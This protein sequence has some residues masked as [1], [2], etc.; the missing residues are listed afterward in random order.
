MVREFKLLNEKGQKYSLMDIEN[1]CLLTGPSGLGYSYN[2]EYEQIGHTFISSLR[3]IQQGAIN[4]TLNF[5][6]YEN[7]KSFVDFVE[8]SETLRFVYEVP[9][10]GTLKQYLKDIQIQ[11]LG[12][13]EMQ[14][15]G[16]ISETV[17]FDCLSLWY[18][19]NTTIYKI[20]PQT[21]EMRWNFRWDSRF[22]EY[23]IRRLIYK[24]QGH[25]EAPVLIEIDGLAKNIIIELYIKKVLYQQVTINATISENEKL[26]YSSTENDFYIRKINSD[27]KVED[28]LNL[29]IID[30]SKDNVVRIP[31]NC[32]CEIR[33]IAEQTIQ[34]AK[35]TVFPRYIAV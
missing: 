9:I 28:L 2:T 31:K 30:F 13:T 27:G 7:Y 10:K 26:L 33:L 1:Y 25:I 5:K 12:K 17:V 16:I 11:S 4:G 15:N 32:D 8:N 22:R 29:D 21:D 3:M 35:I 18:E 34:N 19:E 14:P 23:N 6:S 24:N 20:E